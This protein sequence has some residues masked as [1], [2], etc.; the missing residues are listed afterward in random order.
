MLGLMQDWPLLCHR[1]IDHAAHPARRARSRVA[2]GRRPAP[3]DDL[4]AS[5]RARAQGGATPATR[6]SRARRPGGDACLEHVAASRDLVRH[7]RHRRG[8][9]HDQS[10]AVSRADRLHRQSRR[11]PVDVPRPHLRAADGEAAG[12]AADGRALRGADRRRAH[13]ADGA[14]QRRRLRG[15]DRRGRRRFP[16]GVVRREHR[17][18]HV[19]HVG[20]DRQS[21]GRRLL[22]PLQRAAF[23]DGAVRP[24]RSTCR[25]SDTIM[26]VVPMFHANGWSIAFSAPMAGCKLVL[27]G[28][29]LDGAVG[30]RAAGKRRRHHDGGGADGLADAA[31]AHGSE[32]PQALD[33]CGAC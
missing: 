31:R 20:H 3:P 28:A 2:L 27:P 18:R 19:L 32:Q 30:L 5:A 21:E 25:C 11:R 26:P 4:R 33:A 17:R 24:M 8:L 7:H 12:Q 14:A 16:L 13:A 9:P 15:M 10:A 23:D 22:A 29:K 6:R 1:I